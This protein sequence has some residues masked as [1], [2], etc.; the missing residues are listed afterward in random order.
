MNRKEDTLLTRL[1]VGH[2][3]YTHRHLL[4]G[5]QA[6]MCSQCNCSK[7]P[8]VNIFALFAVNWFLSTYLSS[9]PFAFSSHLFWGRGGLVVRSWPWGRRAPGPRPNSTEDPPCMGPAAGQIIRSGQATS[10]WCGVEAW[11]GGDSPGVV[12]VI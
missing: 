4:F 7:A 8:H 9:A 12:L 1:R 3:L 5:E 6:P 10:L 11:R 2:S